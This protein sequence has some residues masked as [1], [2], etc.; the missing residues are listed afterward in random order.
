MSPSLPGGE[1]SVTASEVGAIDRHLAARG[2]F[3]FHAA[4]PG[5]CKFLGADGRCG[6]CAVRPVDCRVHFRAGESLASR[7]DPEVA[8]LVDAYHARREAKLMASERLDAVRFH[9]EPP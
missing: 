6:V 4:G 5:A 8:A 1:P 3:P 2:P 7:E 9:G